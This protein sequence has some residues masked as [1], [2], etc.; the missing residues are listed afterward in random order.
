MQ[1]FEATVDQ[2]WQLLGTQNKAK[3]CE[4]FYH[5]SLKD[6]KLLKGTR[7]WTEIM[8]R[9]GIPDFN[10]QEEQGENETAL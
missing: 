3:C 10:E 9:E 5:P 1:P 8:E 4:T 2:D 7:Q 6:L